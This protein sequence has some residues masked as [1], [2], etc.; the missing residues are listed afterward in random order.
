MAAD[1][2]IREFLAP[3]SSFLYFVYTPLSPLYP[4]FTRRSL[5]C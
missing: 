2:S 5:I 3:F 4:V 1:G